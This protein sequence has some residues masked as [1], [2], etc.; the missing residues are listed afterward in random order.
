[1]KWKKILGLLLVFLLLSTNVR[2]FKIS[3]KANTNGKLFLMGGAVS[4]D[5]VEIFNALYQEAGGTGSPIIAVICSAAQDL[6]SAQ[7]AFYTDIP[8]HLSYYNL[9]KKYGFTPVFVPIAID[10]YQTAAYDMNNVNLVRNAK[11]VFFNGGDQAKHARCLLKE[12]GSDTPL[13]EA[14]RWVCNNGGVIA[15]T[16]AGTAVQSIKTYGE[17]NSVGYLYHN[18]MAEKEISDI[19]LVDPSDIH[20]HNGGYTYGL[21]LINFAIDTHFDTRGRLGRMIVATRELNMQFGIGIDENTAIS[22][23][24]GI[25]K[26]YGQ[27][28]VFIVDST[29]TTFYQSNYF[30]ADNLYINYL[31]SGDIYDFNLKKLISSKSLIKYPYYSKGFDS[32]D[33][34]APNETTIIITR[35]IDSKWSYCYGDTYDP[36]KYVPIEFTLKFQKISQTKGYYKNGKYSIEKLRV[37][38][39]Y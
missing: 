30:K 39:Y 4:D 9:F 24:N 23:S 5:N 13:M 34:F 7:E 11:V 15:G 6:S 33:I 35:L 17:G 31:T 18:N 25:G 10:N 28:G 20:D 32:S 16:S 26:V 19:S 21:G 1:M 12:D 37:D 2:Y 36:D 38:I 22:I 3:T 14:V 29:D 8:G 27:N